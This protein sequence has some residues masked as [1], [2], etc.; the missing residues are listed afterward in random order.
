MTQEE[1]SLLL[2]DLSA[3]LPYGVECLAG[4]AIVGRLVGIVPYEET[5]YLYLE[6]VLTPYKVEEVKPYLRTMPS[7]NAEEID[8]LFDI[9]HI[10]KNG[11]DGDW[12]KINDSLGMLF[13]FFSGMFV[14]DVAEVY[15]YLNSIHINYRLPKH[16]FVA[17][18]EEN[19][20]YETR[21]TEES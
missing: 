21:R 16:L 19:N 7:M 18:T 5:V 12:I 20:P 8:K 4:D 11:E 10:D 2:Q 9:L 1:K 17:V 13:F 14:E 15:D 6:G 3:R